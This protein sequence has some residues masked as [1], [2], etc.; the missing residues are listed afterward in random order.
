MF[1]IAHVLLVLAQGL[2]RNGCELVGEDECA[3]S[4]VDMLGAK[5]RS[6]TSS[7]VQFPDSPLSS[8]STVYL[9]SLDAV[10]GV[11][12]RVS[13][14]AKRI[15]QVRNLI[16]QYRVVDYVQKAAIKDCTALDATHASFSVA[17]INPRLL[18][19]IA[20]YSDSRGD[21]AANQSALLPVEMRGMANKTLQQLLRC[22]Q[23]TLL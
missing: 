9:S 13:L 17:D 11:S 20:A 14:I 8:N 12:Q 1:R 4:T 18:Q 10:A 2:Q 19:A 7:T 3:A 15:Q 5:D 16:Q 21:S 23:G 22:F 6:S